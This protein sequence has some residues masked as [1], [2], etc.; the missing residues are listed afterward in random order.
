V[1][2]SFTKLLYYFKWFINC[3]SNLRPVLSC[4]MVNIAA[5]WLSASRTQASR[6]PG[7]SAIVIGTISTRAGS[8]KKG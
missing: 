5:D 2:E 8:E 4:C 3:W 1:Y 6:A 7:S